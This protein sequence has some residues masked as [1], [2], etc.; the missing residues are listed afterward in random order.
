MSAGTRSGVGAALGEIGKGLM[1]YTRFNIEDMR[2]KNLEAIRQQERGEDL[3]ARKEDRE[4]RDRFHADEMQTHKDD[5]VQR[6]KEAADSNAT[7][8]ENTRTQK[9]AAIVSAYGNFDASYLAGKAKIDEQRAKIEADQTIVDPE[10]RQRLLDAADAR[11]AALAGTIANQKAAYVKQFGSVLKKWGQFD[12]SGVD[13]AVHSDA[14][15]AAATP[16]PGV[17]DG[18]L[19]MDPNAGSDQAPANPEVQKRVDTLSSSV[20]LATPTG[21]SAKT[22]GLSDDDLLKSAGVIAEPGI[23]KHIAS[24][25]KSTVAAVSDFA[26]KDKAE[27]EQRVADRRASESKQYA[28]MQIAKISRQMDAGKAVDGDA[29]LRLARSSLSD[30]DLKAM[31]AS[32]ALI[33]KIAQLRAT[34]QAQ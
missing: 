13:A 29:L 20:G 31:K 9:E 24:G 15:G 19:L 14:G 2:Q 17:G 22:L 28:A 8:R 25:V 3:Q 16:A 18:S 21:K 33:A 1:E 6:A 12:D 4:T 23:G 5:M 11:E 32:D 26:A 27:S 7:A 10:E 34:S 30:Q